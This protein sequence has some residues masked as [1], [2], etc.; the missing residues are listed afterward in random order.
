MARSA[1]CVA[2][3][4]CASWKSTSAFCVC[5]GEPAHPT[6]NSRPAKNDATM[7]SFLLV[8]NMERLSGEVAGGTETRGANSVGPRRTRRTRMKTGMNHRV[9]RSAVQHLFLPALCFVSLRVLRGQHVFAFP[10]MS[11]EAPPRISGEW[12]TSMQAQRANYGIDAPG[13]VR[14]LTVVAV[15]GAA[16][17]LARLVGLWNEHSRSALL[18][19]PLMYTGLGCGLMAMWMVYDSRVGKVR[20]R[21]RHLDRAGPWRGDEQVL[22]VGCGRGLFLIGAANRLDAARGGRAV[23]IDLWQAEDLSGNNPA[24]TIENARIEGVADRVEVK[25]ADARRLPFADGSFDVV[26]TSMA[27]HNIYNAGER[28]TAV[29][30]IARVLKPGGSR[31]LIVDIR[32]STQ[33]AAALRDAGISDARYRKG[34]VS[35]LLMLITFGSLRPGVVTGTK[36]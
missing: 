20:E 29:R 28:Q 17:L 1:S 4:A 11:W 5:V 36:Q 30:E 14:N 26:V 3:C 15:I 12:G 31:V 9:G 24:A 13:V 25:T 7:R 21:E 34:I 32:H 10:A 22:D 18:F 6:R 23:G 35:Y 27:L 19:Y 16:V 2:S 8:A 33:Y